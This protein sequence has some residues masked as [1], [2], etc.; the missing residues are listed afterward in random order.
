MISENEKD[1]GAL[2]TLEYQK[3]ERIGGDTTFK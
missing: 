1:F 2:K 3:V